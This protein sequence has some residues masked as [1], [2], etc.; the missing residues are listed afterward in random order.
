MDVMPSATMHVAVERTASNVR[1]VASPAGARGTSGASGGGEGSDGFAAHLHAAAEDGSRR[2]ADASAPPQTCRAALQGAQSE[3]P[4][5]HADGSKKADTPETEA[6]VDGEGETPEL[7]AVDTGLAGALG[8]QGAVMQ[9]SVQNLMGAPVGT[10][11]EAL[12]ATVRLPMLAAIPVTTLGPALRM[13]QAG[14]AAQG[15]ATLQAEIQGPTVP[16]QAGSKAT[17]G[18]GNGAEGLLAALAPGMRQDALTQELAHLLSSR[19]GPLPFFGQP[20]V[21]AEG[22]SGASPDAAE[23][24]QAQAQGKPTHTAGLAPKPTAPAPTV[25]TR[26]ADDDKVRATTERA[27]ESAAAT[28]V[29]PDTDRPVAS[30]AATAARSGVLTAGTLTPTVNTSTVAAAPVAPTTYTPSSQSALPPG[31]EASA[32]LRQIGEG[33]SLMTQGARQTAQIRLNPAELGKVQ[34]RLE[35]EGH[36]VRM[37]VTTE[38]AAVRDLVA[39]NLD[40]LR[41]DLLAQGL[42][43]SQVSVDAQSDGGFNRGR[44]DSTPE[45]D[46][47]VPLPDEAT[48]FDLRGRVP[49]GGMTPND[50]TRIDLTA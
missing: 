1:D 3:T 44:Q 11:L 14:L 29:T 13:A 17:S 4:L 8:L 40:G 23:Q 21:A 18:K 37:F 33:L 31:V 10:A 2:H 5:R 45:R 41:R 28:S 43:V 38:N 50:T 27:D 47:T 49:R 16:T 36:S 34:V 35:I 22:K 19:V 6:P 26:S 48:A 15:F 32:V 39:Q 12:P 42:Q 46:E 20:K 9:R 30:A 7:D 25:D 24:A